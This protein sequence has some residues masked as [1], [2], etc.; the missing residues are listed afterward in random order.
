MAGTGAWFTS[1]THLVKSIAAIA[2]AGFEVDD[3]KPAAIAAVVAQHRRRTI[4]VV[5][6]DVE[7]A[8]VVEIARR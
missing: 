3:E 4:E 5:D 6:D 1:W 8:V 7:I 2:S